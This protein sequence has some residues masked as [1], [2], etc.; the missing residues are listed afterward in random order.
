MQ[1]Q[2]AHDPRLLDCMQLQTAHDPQLL[3]CMQLQ[4]EKTNFGDDK[5]LLEQ[6]RKKL[7]R[8]SRV[9]SKLNGM[10]AR[11]PKKQRQVASLY[12]LLSMPAPS[13]PMS[14]LVEAAF[15]VAVTT[16]A[17][18]DDV[19]RNSFQ[20]RCVVQN[21]LRASEKRRRKRDAQMITSSLRSM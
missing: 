1:L 11:R 17:R 4:V 20:K 6:Q 5:S 10:L 21:S 15:F 18:T 2:T 8:S 16:E 9:T 13:L 19:P 12:L 3:D 14:R 7:P